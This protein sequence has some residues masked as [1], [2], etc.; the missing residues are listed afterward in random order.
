[1]AI[2]V[3]L[4]LLPLL[5]M[6]PVSTGMYVTGFTASSSEILLIF[7]FQT[8]FG[9][10]YSAIG[11]IFAIFM[12][13]L[14]M[15]SLAGNRIK[16]SGKHHF[17]GQIFLAVYMLLLPLL[18]KSGTGQLSDF[19]AWL[20][21]IPVLLAPSLLTGF[22]YVTSTLQYPSDRL[23]AAS[24]IYAADLWGSALGVILITFIL[25]PVFGVQMSCLL[26]AGLNGLSA[27]FLLFSKK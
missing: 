2:P 20:L 5:L 16:T 9:N 6:N 11:L 7:W 10:V 18:W 4:L 1:M 24:S 21:F 25:A 27:L 14:A 8:V 13:G 15:G 26:L 22:L 23:N 19:S 3:I 12:G 17:A